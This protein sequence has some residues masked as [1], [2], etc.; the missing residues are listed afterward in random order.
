[1]RDWA[2]K[3]DVPILSIDYSLAPENPYPRAL[4]EIF[5]TYCWVLK[6]CSIL[7]AT[8]KKI[9][10]AGDSAG[11][12]LNAACVV[13]IIERGIQKPHGMLAMFSPF[14]LNFCSTP[15]K[16]LTFVDPLLPFG[17]IMRVF[18]YYG[19]TEAIEE[20]NNPK[21]NEKSCCKLS[22][23]FSDWMNLNK[24]IIPPAT[25]DELIFNV[26]ENPYLSPYRAEDEILRQFPQT[27]ILSMI[28]DPCLD[29]C[30]E[31]SKKLRRL[32]VTVS[33][34]ILNG[35]NHGFL[36]FTKLSIDCH[37][38]SMYCADLVAQLIMSN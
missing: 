11:G 34:D 20:L 37:R 35:I 17:F 38:A 8:G 18:K 31:F 23:L 5:Y 30:V 25:D 27:K 28:G 14:Y 36:N 12:N 1:M 9:I 15:A 33:L 29:D 10:F 24:S 2:I 7:G 3:L 16:Y 13:K 26:P 6:N 19:S 21:M 32:D 22:Y 4:E